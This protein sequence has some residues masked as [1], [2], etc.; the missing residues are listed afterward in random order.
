MRMF[1]NIA[2]HRLLPGA[3][4]MA[5]SFLFM[6]VGWLGGIGVCYLGLVVG[7]V[8]FPDEM[9]AGLNVLL[10]PLVGG[11][12]GLTA[13]H[14]IRVRCWARLQHRYMDEYGGW[15][16]KH[17]IGVILFDEAIWLAAFTAIW[18]VALAVL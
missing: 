16:W 14:I 7:P 10:F 8:E 15:T 1:L 2:K 11:N 9:Y 5:C 17:T 12:V 4:W 3:G 13:K 18:A 6:F